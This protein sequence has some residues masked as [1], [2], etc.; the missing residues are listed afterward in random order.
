MDVKLRLRLRIGSRC[1][2]STPGAK[3]CTQETNCIVEDPL[4][5]PLYAYI[6]QCMY[7][8]AYA[9]AC[10]EWKTSVVLPASFTW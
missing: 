2:S 1:H 9:H 6:Y 10:E 8:N 7:V 4:H 5:V 3:Q